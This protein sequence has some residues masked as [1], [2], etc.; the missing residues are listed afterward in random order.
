[1]RSRSAIPCYL[2]GSYRSEMDPLPPRPRSDDMPDLPVDPHLPPVV[3]LVEMLDRESKVE[4]EVLIVAED[5]VVRQLVETEFPMVTQS[6]L[7][8]GVHYRFLVSESVRGRMQ[9]FLDGPKLGALR[10]RIE[11]R[12]IDASVIKLAT[13]GCIF[14]P[15]LA[16]QHQAYVRLPH[17]SGYDWIELSAG[18]KEA[19]LEGFEALWSLPGGGASVAQRLV[20]AQLVSFLGL[21]SALLFALGLPP[22]VRPFLLTVYNGSLPRTLAATAVLSLTFWVAFNLLV[23]RIS[24]RF[25]RTRYAQLLKKA[26]AVAVGVVLLGMFVNWLSL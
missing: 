8:K 20:E 10:G 19:Y 2:K 3:S 13:P 14:D 17:D 5:R 15:N 24:Y 4:A 11:V 9:D 6:N 18:H 25:R 22:L 7:A 12:A 16:G 1:M 26:L 21:P 23:T